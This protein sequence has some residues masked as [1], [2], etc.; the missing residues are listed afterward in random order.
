MNNQWGSSFFANY[1][2]LQQNNLKAHNWQ[3]WKKIFLT[4]PCNEIYRNEEQLVEKIANILK[5]LQCDYVEFGAIAWKF[6]ILSIA[7]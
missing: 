6:D 1:A 4:C 3:K 5:N 7:A 2:A